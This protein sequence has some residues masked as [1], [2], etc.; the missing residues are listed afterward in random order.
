MN[1]FAGLILL[2]VS[3]NLSWSASTLLAVDTPTQSPPEQTALFSEWGQGFCLSDGEVK[4][5]NLAALN[6]AGFKTV[7]LG[8]NCPAHT[9]SA[10]PYTID[11]A[12]LKKEREAVT[13][14][15]ANHLHV[16]LCLP[17]YE[18]IMKDPDQE[19]DRFVA[20]WTQVAES[21]KDLPDSLAFELLPEPAGGLSDPNR[22]NKLVARALAGIRQN[23]PTRLILIGPAKYYTDL[24][25]LVL[26]END[27]NIALA[28]HVWLISRDKWGTD[29]Q[30][31]AITKMMDRYAT[32]CRAHKRPLFLTA[33]AAYNGEDLESGLLWLASIT[34]ETAAYNISWVNAAFSGGRFGPYDP[35]TGQWNH[36]ILQ[37]LSG[38]SPPASAS[39]AAAAAP[40]SNAQA[41]S[42]NK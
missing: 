7:E 19:G 13:L 35:K 11:P 38:I 37:A 30:K 3:Y 1:K 4:K 20:I 21:F 17:P 29:V 27:T 18:A 24:A 8:F 32:W 41:K 36:A 10:A 42:G 9:D 39:S 23:C 22:W 31:Q 28:F 16:I 25:H 14:I 5:E 6:Q 12:F 40:S 2:C 33:F 34:H 15:Q 26:P